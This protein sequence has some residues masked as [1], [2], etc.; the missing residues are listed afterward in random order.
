MRHPDLDAAHK[1][2]SRHRAEVEA[3]T[4]CGCFY[5]LSTFPPTAITGWID[6]GQTALCPRCPVDAVLGSASG[7]PITSDF[8]ERM[9]NRWF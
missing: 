8:L 2:S 1:H 7:L 5:C 4:V 6:D 3:S 9:H